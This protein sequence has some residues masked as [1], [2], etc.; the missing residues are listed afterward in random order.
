MITLKNI[1][2]IFGTKRVLENVS[3]SVGEGQKVAIVGQNGAGKSTLLKIIAGLETPDRGTVTKPHRILTG[4]LPQEALAY[5]DETLLHYLRRMAGLV[6][7]EQEM[8]ALEPSLADEQ[9][10]QKYEL[11]RMEYERL[12]GY[13]FTRQARVLLEG[14]GLGQIA[15]ERLVSELSGGERRKAALAG[16]LARGVDLLLLDEPTNNLDLPALLWLERSLKQSAAT[17]IIASHDRRFLDHVVEKIIE[18]DWHRRDAM[19]FAGGWST[20]AIM[21]ARKIRQQKA[22]HRAQEE[23]RER[24]LVSSEQKKEWVERTRLQKAPDHDTL[25]THY[26]KERATRKFTLSAKALADR[27]QRLQGGEKVRERPALHMRFQGTSGDSNV[28]AKRLALIHAR[29]GYPDGFQGGL[30][31][32]TL[33]F[34]S[35]IALLGD[36]GAGKSTLLATLAGHLR[37]LGGKRHSGTGL[38]FGFLVQEHAQMLRASTPVQ[39]FRERTPLDEREQIALHLAEFQF[40]PTILDDS[41][42]SLSPGERVRLTLALLAAQGANVLFLDEPTNHLDLEAIEA[43]EEALETYQGTLVVVTHDRLFLERLRLTA[44]YLLENGK[45]SR[46]ENPETITPAPPDLSRTSL[47]REVPKGR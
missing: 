21:K 37:L 29:F 6:A 24:L 35:R 25:A 44:F 1:R 4:Y 23:E 36:N 11:L 30:L 31:D 34:G 16:V 27:Q 12:G 42:L 41:V 26:K 28:S 33:P 18:I 46:V 2:K 47:P 38:V 20:F 15:T 8:Q 19:L 3:F 39:I 14:L 22:A 40:S 10:L 13:D 17:V 5:A 43:L 45:L 9:A 7:L 32:L